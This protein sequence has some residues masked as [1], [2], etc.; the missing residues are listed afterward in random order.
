VTAPTTT[1]LW[2]GYSLADIDRLARIAAHRARGGQL[3]DPADRY[4]TA[5]SHIAEALCTAD[6]PPTTNYLIHVGYKAINRASQDHRRMWGMARTWEAHE[7]DIR[8]YMRYWELE[9]RSSAS[10]EDAIV[11]RHALLQIWPRL[12]L[13]HRQVLYAVAI[14]DGDHRAAADSLGKTLVTFRTHLKDAR[15]AFRALWHEH[16]TPSR[17]WGKSGQSGRRNGIQTLTN[18][19]RQRERRAQVAA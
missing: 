14:H 4:Q 15:A 18:R 10:P 5:W 19:R 17:M 6:E 12:S 16:E 9:R 2:H 8:A 1:N 13:T 11:D 7:G 3:L